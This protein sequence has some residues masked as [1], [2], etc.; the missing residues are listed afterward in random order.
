M[1]AYVGPGMGAATIVIVVIVLLLVAL[2]LGVVLV[3]PIKRAW[4]NLKTRFGS[5]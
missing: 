1:L 5:K 4:A 2:S 3:R